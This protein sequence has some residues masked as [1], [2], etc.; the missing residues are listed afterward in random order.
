M[1]KSHGFSLIEVAV[2]LFAASLLITLIMQ[3]FLL[4][5]RQYTLMQSRLEQTFELA[6]LSELIR[7]SIRQ[8]GFTPCSGISSLQ[9]IDKRNGKT[10]TALG[11]EKELKI[12]RMSE[13]FSTVL[14]QVDPNQF[15]V[16]TDRSYEKDQPVLIADCYHAEVQEIMQARRTSEGTIINLKKPLEFQYESPI[17]FGEWIEE[18][19]FIKKNNQGNNALFYQRHHV[20]ELS[21]FVDNLGIDLKISKGK[22]LVEATLETKLLQKIKIITEVRAG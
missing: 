2:S 19:F 22:T 10:L 20:D 11:K 21:S 4:S 5:K 13:H 14:K 17:Y 1:R 16:K 6:E 12:N 9:T 8:A 7:H 3:Q 15:L 18:S